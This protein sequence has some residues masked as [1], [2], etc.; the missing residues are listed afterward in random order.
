MKRPVIICANPVYGA[1]GLSSTE[2][3]AKE[4]S[5]MRPVLFVNFPLTLNQLKEEKSRA[6]NSNSLTRPSDH[7]NLWVYEPPIM[8]PSNALKGMSYSVVNAINNKRYLNGLKRVLRSLEWNSFDAVNAFNPTYSNAFLKLKAQTYT[9]YCYD[10]IAASHWMRNHGVRLE[11]EMIQK[12]DKI[13]VS[14][15]GLA[16]KFAQSNVPVFLVPNGMNAAHFKVVDTIPDSELIL[17][18]IGALDDRL[19]YALIDNLLN[20]DVVSQ[21]KIAG[22]LNVQEA[23]N[24]SQHRKV[25]YLGILSK[26]DVGAALE[27]T[28]VGLIPFVANEFTKYIY[29]LK[30]NEYLAKGLAVLSTR[31][32]DLSEFKEV[33]RPVENS[34]QAIEELH[35]IL[36]EEC[37]E[38]A[39]Q[40]RHKFAS[41]NTWIK[42][43]EAF[44]DAL[45]G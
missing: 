12:V 24:L 27:G 43:A 39:K 11:S 32:A 13:I 33:V 2:E 41:A 45:D 36:K 42:R 4:L 16:D 40:C 21:L 23:V 22:P 9:Y 38:E 18:Y 31:F 17:V 6:S 35:R 30:I 10:N 44:N 5:K 7:T 37:T 26:D 28:N 15:A 3:I 34:I 19:D 14:S 25:E 8:L 1:A 20:E 29:P